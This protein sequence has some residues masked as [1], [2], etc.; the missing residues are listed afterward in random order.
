VDESCAFTVKILGIRFTNEKFKAGKRHGEV[1]FC[2][3]INP[4]QSPFKKGRR[5]EGQ[6][7]KEAETDDDLVSL[8][9]GRGR[10]LVHPFGKGSQ[11]GDLRCRLD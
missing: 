3:Y 8:L 6:F 2:H 5:K 7:R 10:I 11:G 9:F 4:S 1:G